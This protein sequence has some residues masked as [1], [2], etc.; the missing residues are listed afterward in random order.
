ADLPARV[1]F[2]AGRG[3]HVLVALHI[4]LPPDWF[5]DIAAGAAAED[6]RRETPR[7][8][9]ASNARR[10]TARSVLA[11]ATAVEIVVLNH[12]PAGIG[13]LVDVAAAAQLDGHAELT[14]ELRRAPGAAPRPLRVH[15]RHHARR[16]DGIFYGC[17]FAAHA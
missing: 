4:E 17:M 16:D 8:R 13:F 5:R 3:A 2:S 14:L 6:D 10:A 1:L 11:S 7:V 9:T 15:V 12:S